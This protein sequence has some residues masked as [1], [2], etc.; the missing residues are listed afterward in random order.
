MIKEQVDTKLWSIL[1]T[2][3]NSTCRRRPN[4]QI[5]TTTNITST[6]EKQHKPGFVEEILHDI[7]VFAVLVNIA[8]DRLQVGCS[9]NIIY[10]FITFFSMIFFSDELT[11]TIFIELW[12]KIKWIQFCFNGTKNDNAGRSRNLTSMYLFCQKYKMCSFFAFHIP[13]LHTLRYI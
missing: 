2:N 5:K 7:N 1:N 9:W 11:T 10:F 4:L 6:V 13:I 3:H 12:L 8:K